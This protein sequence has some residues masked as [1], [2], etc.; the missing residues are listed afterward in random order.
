MVSASQRDMTNVEVRDLNTINI[1]SEERKKGWMLRDSQQESLQ[2]PPSF[3]FE[4]PI[5]GNG[6]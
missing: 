5:S 6:L 3:E 2:R 4:S 1:G